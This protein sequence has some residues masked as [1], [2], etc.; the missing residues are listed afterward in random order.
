MKS[1][2]PGIAATVALTLLGMAQMNAADGVRVDCL[3]EGHTLVRVADPDGV[4][5]LPVEDSAPDA[6]VIVLVD[7]RRV[8]EFKVRLAMNRADYTV[9][10]DLSKYKDKNLTLD[11]YTEAGRANIRSAADAAWSKELTPASAF[12]T[13]DRESRWRPVYHHTPQYGWMNDPNGMFYKDGRWHMCYQFGPY[14]STWNNMTWGHS[15]SS[16]LINWEHH[17]PV[18]HPDG[19]GAIFSGCAVVDKDNT[20]GFGRDAIIAV[21]TSAG[22]SQM[23]SLAYSTDGG[24]TFTPFAGN[25]IITSMKECRDP[26]IFR[27]EPSGKWIMT[28]ACALDHQIWIYSST[29]LKNWTKESEFGGYGCRDGVWECPDLMELPVRGSDEKRWVLVCNIN[30]G[31]IYGGSAT[32]YFV[33]SFDGKTFKCDSDPAVT[34]W[35]DYGKDHYAAVSWNNAPEG[36]HTMIAWM[37]NWQYAAIVPT[38]QYRSANALPRDVE[39]YR[40]DNGELYVASLPSPEVDAARGKA[41]SLGGFSA[42]KKAVQKAIPAACQGAFEL[43]IQL[44]YGSASK[45]EIVLSNKLGEQVTLSYNAS[46]ATFAIDRRSSGLISYSDDFPAVTTA[47]APK[48]STQ[49][50]RLFVDRSSL[51]AFDAEGR[52]AMT[53]IVFPTEPY[54][55]VSVRAIGGKAKVKSLK[56]YPIKTNK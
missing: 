34:K 29:D 7:N 50:L 30:P 53:D 22:A 39:L 11:V 41:V 52:F 8:D 42:G 5:L 46:D 43:D 25:P 31:G 40:G 49:S 18:L 20:A 54:S 19:L 13:T 51:E 2:I 24:M 1:I 4:L 21:Y 38:Q 35:M 17:A 48:S 10:F 47:P 44:Q 45:V 9:P 16:D 3:G 14:G 36:R 55:I 28:L 15:S 12:D 37:S 32:Q 6:T 26:H 56:I 23:Q 33:G 27:H